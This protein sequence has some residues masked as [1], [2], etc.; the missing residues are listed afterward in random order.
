M[1]SG[2]TIA[3]ANALGYSSI[4]VERMDEYYEMSKQAIRRL[5]ALPVKDAQ[6]ELSFAYEVPHT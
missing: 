6:L 3:A 4:G 5:S 2:S 1:G